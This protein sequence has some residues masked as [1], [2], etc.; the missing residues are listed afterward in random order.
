MKHFR[1]VYSGFTD[2]ESGKE[3]L[4]VLL[5][6]ETH[7]EAEEASRKYVPKFS[8]CIGCYSKKIFEVSERRFSYIIRKM[9]KDRKDIIF[10]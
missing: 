5:N 1:I 2:K 6:A 7:E 10:L 8:G 4:Y 9:L 3:K